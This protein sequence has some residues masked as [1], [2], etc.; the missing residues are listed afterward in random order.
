[1]TPKLILP[2]HKATTLT[3]FYYYNRIYSLHCMRRRGF[4]VFVVPSLAWETVSTGWVSCCCVDRRQ[5]LVVA[6]RWMAPLAPPIT[7]GNCHSFSADCPVPR[8]P[9]PVICCIPEAV[10][11]ARLSSFFIIMGVVD[12]RPSSRMMDGVAEEFDFGN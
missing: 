3:V 6:V 8:H 4:P 11:E 1:M 5:D 2:L 10:S 12:F 7:T 9:A